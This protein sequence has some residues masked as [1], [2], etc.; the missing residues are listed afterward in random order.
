MYLVAS[1]S[2]LFVVSISICEIYSLLCFWD[3]SCKILVESVIVKLMY[4]VQL[5]KSFIIISVVERGHIYDHC[6]PGVR[7]SFY[8]HLS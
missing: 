6:Q 4:V 2:C 3:V 7:S 8:M 1:C 5:I